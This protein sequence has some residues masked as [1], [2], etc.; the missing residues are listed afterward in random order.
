MGLA[1]LRLDR[2]LQGPLVLHVLRAHAHDPPAPQLCVPPA[3]LVQSRHHDQDDL[4]RHQQAPPP[5]DPQE[6][7]Q[8]VPLQAKGQDP[9]TGP[10]ERPPS[11]R[12]IRVVPPVGV[13]Q[14]FKSHVFIGGKIFLY[15]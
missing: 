15:L 7:S 10:G 4:R 13:N 12:E 1:G 3:A 11:G 5:K 9:A 2:A 6:L 14:A 8:G